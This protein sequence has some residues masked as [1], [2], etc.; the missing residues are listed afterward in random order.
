MAR[1]MLTNGKTWITESYNKEFGPFS[2]YRKATDKE[3]EA[4]YGEPIEEKKK[5]VKKEAPKE[6]AEN[7]ED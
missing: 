1:V 7:T 6:V 4:R 2:G 5:K 3:L